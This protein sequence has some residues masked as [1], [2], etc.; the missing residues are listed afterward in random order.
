MIYWLYL[1][2]F[3]LLSVLEA[4]EI[5]M[6]RFDKQNHKI[7]EILADKVS[8]KDN[9]ITASGNAILLNYDVYILADKVRYD[10]KTKEAL[11][12]G[13]IKVYRGEGLLVKTDYVKLS[14]NEKYEIIFPF[15]VQDSVSGIWVSA[16]IASGKDQK[17]KVKNMSASGCSIDN[18]IWHVNAT[19]G[20]FNMQ[21]SHLSMWNPKIYV[22]DIPV[23]Y[24]PYIF[25]STSN[26]R[27]TGFL[28]PEF[29]TSNL[30]G[31]I[32]LQP[33]YLAPKN[34]WDMTFTPQIRYKRGFGLN[35]EARYIN[36]KNDRF[37][38]NARYFRNYTQYV[39]RYDLRNQ[40]IYGFEFLSSSRDTLQKYFHLK[41]N[42]DNGHYI[43][44]LY[45]ND[46][47]YVRFEKV[48]K[49]ITD[50]THMSRANYYLQTENNYYGLNIKY[51]LNLNKINNNRT[52]QSVPNLQYHKYLNS[53]Y[54]KNLLY[55]VDYQFRNTAR[56]IGYG[57][58]QNALNVPVG[59][60]F[61]LFKKYLSIGLWNDLQLSNVAL[62]QSKN[63]FVPT[64]PNESREFGNFVSSNFSMY[65]NTDLAREYN[66]LFHTIQLEAI[67]NIPYYTFKNGLFSQN[68]YAL[69]VQALNSYTSPLLRDYDYQ[70]RLYD[71]VWNPS[72]ILPS[73]ASNK[74]VDLTLT[75]YLYGLGGQELLYFKISQ[76]I[77]LDDKVSPFRMPLESKIGFSPLTGL[78]IFGNVFYSFYQNRLEEISVNAN[79]QRKFLS[80][81]LSYFLRNNFSSGIN[82]IV[83]NPADYLKA[84][85]S[86]DFGYF[87]MSADVGYDIRN[88]V[89]LNWNV[90]IYKKIRCFGIGFQFV[91]QRR[92]I[93]TG[94]SNQPIRV[95]ENNYVK[96]ELDF[97]PIT[98]TNVT[99]RSLQHK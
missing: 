30:D 62:M 16:D 69:S 99:Y 39:K 26:K 6:Q 87:S 97:S 57:Y 53:L 19:S 34:S 76:L 31:F 38:F 28:Y 41:S 45:M 48:N 7:F 8:A 12:E 95:F 40:N 37:L 88:N 85:F 98:K 66:K 35:F 71:S 73:N 77:N 5:A 42:I 89:V 44:F 46:L 50:A 32:Y 90:G 25:M 11:L 21:K 83:E 14:L 84:G 86:N 65:V 2:V 92:P 23:L 59:L 68:M 15:Y 82:S 64:I 22:G 27:T 55:S 91:N 1:A 79:Y 78:N 24:L 29:G 81:N 36:S 43:D 10:T 56:E 60:Q 9:V 70:G 52:F 63:S 74:T 49:R 51:F 33:F 20:S 61:S 80:F 67:F 18:P 93:L 58:V 75:Q 96:L 3:F 94:D 47:D 13:N 4:K 72:S 54:F 17:Y